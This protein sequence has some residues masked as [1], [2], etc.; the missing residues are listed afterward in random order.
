MQLV[1]P[2]RLQVER[3]YHNSISIGRGPQDCG[4]ELDLDDIN[5]S[6]EPIS[7]PVGEM[8]FSPQGILVELKVRGRR[9]PEWQ[10]EGNSA[11]PIPV[12]RIKS[13]EEA[14]ELILIPYGCTNLRV[15]EFPLL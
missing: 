13:S 9:V 7:K 4:L 11:G 14:E 12:S 15:T 10:L 5:G 3:R 2:M 6:V 8:L 1:L